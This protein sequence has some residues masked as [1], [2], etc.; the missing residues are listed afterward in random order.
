[1]QK[2]SHAQHGKIAIDRQTDGQSG[3]VTRPT[4]TFGEAS[5]KTD[6]L[7]KELSIVVQRHQNDNVKLSI[8]T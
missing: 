1:L 2:E 4:V 6:I 3:A 7:F 8:I 5:S